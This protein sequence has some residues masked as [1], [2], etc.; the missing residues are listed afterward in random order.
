MET[1]NSTAG[2]GYKQDREQILSIYVKSGE[3]RKVAGRIGNKHTDDSAHD[4][5]DQ[6]VAV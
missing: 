2:D 6:Q 3:C 5:E 1:G 4:H